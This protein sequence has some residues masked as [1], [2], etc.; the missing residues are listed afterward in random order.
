MFQQTQEILG[1]SITIF[2]NS[3][4]PSTEIAMET[5]FLEAKRIE[6]NYSRFIEQ[7]LLSALNEDIGSWKNV[8]DEMFFLL[9]T[10][11]MLEEK[12]KGSFTLSVKSILES[13]GYNANYEL[14]TET[15]GGATGIFELDEQK[16]R[17]KLS[18]SLELGGVGKGFALDRMQEVLSDFEN[19]FINA[20]GDIYA[21]GVSEENIPWKVFLEHP[22]DYTKVLGEV[23]LKNGFFAGSSPIRRAWRN[24]HHLIDARTKEPENTMLATFIK[25][26][27]GILADGF[28]TALFSLGYEDAKMLILQ[29]KLSAMLIAKNG[30][31]FISPWFEV[32]FY[33]Q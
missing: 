26:E 33:E 7:N 29:E 9:Q 23:V 6:Q 19:I 4:S 28:S 16:K 8:S 22:L 27:S 18:A 17:V 30:D 1:T 32:S 12:T 24:R 31:V 11:K 14:D 15:G 25:H 2:I 21:R 20:G 10:G 13:W 5:A 3:P